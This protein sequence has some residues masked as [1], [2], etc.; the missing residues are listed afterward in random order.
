MTANNQKVS[1][2]QQILQSLAEML[3]DPSAKI[4]T[5]T[6]AKHVG[7]SEAALYRHFPS[8]TR[9]FEGLLDYM[10]EALFSRVNQISKSEK[11]PLEK[12]Y[13]LSTLFIVFAERN[14]GFCR[15]MTG[16]AITGEHERLHARVNKIFERFNF[17]VKQIIKQAEL[18][19]NLKPTILANAEAEL[20][21]SLVQGKIAGYVRSNFQ[22][23]PSEH[24]QRQFELIGKDLFESL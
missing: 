1:R 18:Q 16:E 6:L 5:A 22:Q 7:V 24:W 4:T 14:P 13:E 10:D 17:E 20:I 19:A 15:L 9:M 2:S 21:T 23:L 3:Q 12:I 8:K 11:T